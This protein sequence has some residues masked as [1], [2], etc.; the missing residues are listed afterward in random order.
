ML[1]RTISPVTYVVVD[2][3]G[4]TGVTAPSELVYVH[5]SARLV[6]TGVGAFVGTTVGAAV[7]NRDGLAVARVGA[8]VGTRVDI[9]V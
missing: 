9:D 4:R 6:G 3:H 7:G 8:F 2:D 5:S 1:S